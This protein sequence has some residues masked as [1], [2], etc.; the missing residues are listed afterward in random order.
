MLRQ[1]LDSVA[2]LDWPNFEC[3][4]VINNTPDPAHWGPIED[5]CRLLGP[6]FKFVRADQLQ[7][8]KA[9]ALR[10]A[11]EHTA[12]EAE[13]IGVLDADYVVHPGLAEGPGAGVCRSGGRAGAGAAG[14]PRR[15]EDHH[16][17][18]HESRIRG[19][20]RHRHGGAKRGQRHRHARHDVP[21]PAR[22][23]PCRRRLVERHHRR[24]Y[25]SW[26]VRCSS[27]GWRAHYTQTR[28]G[29]GL[30]PSDFA[31]YKRQRHRWAYGGVQLIKK[32][33][34]AFLPGGSR[35]T[36]Q[37]RSQ[38]L[39]G[40]LTW[41]GAEA[42]G[43]LIAILN[44]I[45]MPLVAFLRHRRAGGR[46]HASRARHLRGHAAAFHGALPQAGAGADLRLAR[47]GA[48]G[49]GPA[50]HRRPGRGRRRDQGSIAV[51]AHG[52]GR[53]RALVSDPS[54]RFGKPCSAA[55]SCSGR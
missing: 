6:R 51:R 27:A 13:I 49:H 33:W 8:F 5:H 43:V 21:D 54:R 2:K 41:L 19:L 24:G 35:L 16:P 23:A 53:R 55:C 39:F 50:I 32:H 11:L 20:L 3:V 48:F 28:Y 47:G 37:Q 1:T 42:L 44:L 46:A 12:P 4:V 52:Q 45:W 10:L 7:G 30:L 34:R 25:R 15:V 14:S 36:P 22:G 9:G 38:Y 40:W 29:W 31:A 26:P 18:G 17:S